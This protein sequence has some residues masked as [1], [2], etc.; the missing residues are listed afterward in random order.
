MA[1]LC[2]KNN[3][4]RWRF[5]PVILPVTSLAPFAAETPPTGF[6]GGNFGWGPF[7]N[8]N[9][10]LTYQ[11]QKY[12]FNLNVIQIV[13]IVCLL[14]APLSTSSGGTGCTQLGRPYHQTRY[15]PPR[16]LG[17]QSGR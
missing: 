14:L 17:N 13:L 1:P 3:S 8:L 5:R 15:M 9:Q 2:R 12:Q 16:S 7:N 4:S 10:Q 6:Y 11:Q